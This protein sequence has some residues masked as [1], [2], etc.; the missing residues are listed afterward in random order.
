MKLC[1]GYVPRTYKG[2]DKFKIK[3]I[4]ASKADANKALNELKAKVAKFGVGADYVIWTE[5]DVKKQWNDCKV[6]T[7]QKRVK[8]I[9]KRKESGKLP[10]FVLCPRCEAKS[11]KLYSEMGGLQTRVCRNGHRFAYD[12][13]V[14]MGR[15]TQTYDQFCEHA[16]P[17][18]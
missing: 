2:N 10:V 4:H 5:D 18:Y 6:V 11:R 14:G 8:A 15:Y 16:K 17:G 9:E 12:T 3:S 7:K 1:V 13:F